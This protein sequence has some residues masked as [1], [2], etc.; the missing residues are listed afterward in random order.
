MNN[1]ID[2]LILC[3]FIFILTFIFCIIII[4]IHIVDIKKAIDRNLNKISKVLNKDKF[5][6]IKDTYVNIDNIISIYI[7]E[8][9]QT[10]YIKT[11]VDNHSVHIEDY[12]LWYEY[13][14]YLSKRMVVS[15]ES[16][17]YKQ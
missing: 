17:Y 8:R 3:L 14:Q 12:G 6:I 1:P 15:N 9:N 10:V 5:I 7:S 11:L 2:T 4:S 16:E 13:L